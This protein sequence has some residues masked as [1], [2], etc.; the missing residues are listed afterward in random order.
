M[1]LSKIALYYAFS[2]LSD[3]EAV[4][5][6]QRALCERLRLTG[7]ILVSPHGING[8]VGGRLED[9]KA[10]V[11]ETRSYPGFRGMDVKYSDGSAED[12]PRLS[13]KA[14]PELVAFGAP[15]ELEVDENGVVGG[16][17]PL[18]PEAVHELVE[19]R[20][21][22]GR[23]VVFFDGR[24]ASEAEIG[25]FTGAVV[26]DVAT[27]HDFIA[28]LDSGKYDHLKNESVVTYCTGGVRCEVLSALMVKRGFTD[29]YQIEGG[30][31]RYGE[32]FGDKGLW[33]G[34]LYVF[35]RRMSVT[36]SEDAAVI[37]RCED[38]GEP[39]STLRNCADPGCRTL[40][41]YCE[42]HTDRTEAGPCAGCRERAAA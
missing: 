27:T 40:K 21:A 35:D 18:A 13:V 39:T 8:T 31:V 33:E 15:E 30:I 5:L 32:T 37:G 24:N 41:P 4:R 9:V 29:V 34:S 36:F 12:F 19:R 14:R 28:E 25:R 11:R 38:C 6:W 3:P 7:R 17:T 26:P 1:A 22:E 2:P 20:R 10:Y 42:A 16:G 23:D